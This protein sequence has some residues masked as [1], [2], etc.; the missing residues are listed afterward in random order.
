MAPER[1]HAHQLIDRLAPGQ[2]T[3][4]VNLLEILLEDH[5]EEELSPADR[6][7]VAESREYFRQGGKG[8][9]FEQVLSDCGFTM[10]DI[11]NA[12]RQP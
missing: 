1:V 3:A 4:V 8:L 12:K 11:W 6:Q 10:Q 9:T 7:A 5:R 2:L